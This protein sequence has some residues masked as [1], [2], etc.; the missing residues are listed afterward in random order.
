M[1][2][3]PTKIL[4]IPPKPENQPSLLDTISN[5]TPNKKLIDTHEFQNRLGANPDEDEEPPE[6]ISRS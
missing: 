6:E 3:V 4:V 5:I 1:S 2:S